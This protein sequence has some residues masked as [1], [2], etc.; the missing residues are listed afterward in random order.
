M[1]II[2]FLTSWVAQLC[3]CTRL[4]CILACCVIRTCIILVVRIIP[5]NLSKA[6]W[7]ARLPCQSWTTW[8]KLPVW[9]IK[10]TQLVPLSDCLKLVCLLWLLCKLYLLCSCVSHYR[11]QCLENVLAPRWST[12]GIAFGQLHMLS[13]KSRDTWADRWRTTCRLWRGADY[14]QLSVRSR[15]VRSPFG[16]KYR[17]PEDWFQVFRPQFHSVQGSVWCMLGFRLASLSLEAARPT[18]CSTA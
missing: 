9:V 17:Y 11:S 15:G 2:G 1:S 7:R 13:D 5:K 4:Q 10:P 14:V 12:D 3:I 18:E 8:E 6:L 16:Q